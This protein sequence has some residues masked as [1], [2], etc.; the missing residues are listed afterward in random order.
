M[1]LKAGYSLLKPPTLTVTTTIAP[2]A[3]HELPPG[4]PAA[5][6]PAQAQA[7]TLHQLEGSRLQ[8]ENY[9]AVSAGPAKLCALL[10][11]KDARAA[12]SLRAC[13]CRGTAQNCAVIRCPSLS[14]LPSAYMQAQSPQAGSSP[15][16]E[17]MVSESS[18]KPSLPP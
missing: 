17:V 6:S 7:C 18:P 16:E 2:P 4:L 8:P 15:M 12:A 11:C 5:G 3:A 10:Q 9:I 1:C 13:V 14:Q